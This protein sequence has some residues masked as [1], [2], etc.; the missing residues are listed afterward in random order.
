MRF[1]VNCQKACKKCDDGR[2][3]Q[4]CIRY[5][6]ES[7][8]T[9]SARRER[10]RG[11]RRGPYRRR[12][13]SVLMLTNLIARSH[14][15][16]PQE[17]CC[18]LSTHD[19]ECCLRPQDARHYVPQN[20]RLPL[21]SSV[22]L[23]ALEEASSFFI[24]ASIDGSMS[25]IAPPIAAPT[26]RR[27]SSQRASAQ[28][29]YTPPHTRFPVAMDALLKAHS[30]LDSTSNNY[31]PADSSHQFC[32]PSPCPQLYA[33]PPPSCD[34]ASLR[35]SPLPISRRFAVPSLSPS[36]SLSWR[37][38]N[39]KNPCTTSSAP[40]EQTL[41]SNSAMHATSGVCS[42]VYPASLYPV[43]SVFEDATAGLSA[44]SD[45]CSNELQV[46][47]CMLVGEAAHVLKSGH[48]RVAEPELAKT[49]L[50]PVKLAPVPTNV[51]P[52]PLKV[53]SDPSL[54][55]FGASFECQMANSL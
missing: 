17:G 47:A 20:S 3:C 41:L 5:H 44:L 23:N 42:G 31:S 28:R 14:G 13:S 27:L 1:I 36:P 16:P 21:D 6:L 11:V 49:E 4:R 39:E 40:W 29:F 51:E 9:N 10:K 7:T 38:F 18:C 8:C 30:P 55:S 15:I 37:D 12:S 2:P 22:P 43:E 33:T 34:A 54:S 46:A 35:S 48:A 25:S 19:A 50:L 32:Y 53:A 45:L 24:D 26:P 52:F